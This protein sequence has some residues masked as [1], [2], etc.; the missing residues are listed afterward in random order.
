M[1]LGENTYSQAGGWVNQ[2]KAVTD[3]SYQVCLPAHAA[4]R[5]PPS[6]C[7][8]ENTCDALRTLDL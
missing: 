6:Q 4:R 2:F 3:D 1:S 7:P 5:E 8:P